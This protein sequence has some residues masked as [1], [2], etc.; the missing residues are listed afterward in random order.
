MWRFVIPRLTEH[1]RVVA[2]EP[3]GVGRSDKLHGGYDTG[4]VAAE[5]AALV[6]E[7]G[8]DRFAV[9]GH[10]IG[11]WLGYAL[12]ADHA[13][14][15]ERLALLDAT[16]PGL[17]PDIPFFGSE[18]QND[19]LWH[20]AFNRKRSVNEL[21]VSGREHIY[22]GDQ[23]RLKAARPL[24]DSA[25]DFYVETIAQLRT[26]G[27]SSIHSPCR[28]SASPEPGDKANDSVPSSAS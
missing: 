9:A 5:L 21:L 14:A 22:Y 24:P 16:I 18:A 10:D 11:M 2:V 3:R 25:V 15:V 27:A 7:L 1:F 19:L 17:A 4:T 6:R 8:H 20:F 12:A 26:T 13:D 23:F 28:S